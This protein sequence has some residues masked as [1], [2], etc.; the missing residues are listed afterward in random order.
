MSSKRAKGHSGGLLIYCNNK[1][2]GGIKLVKRNDKGIMW[3]KLTNDPPPPGEI[4]AL[5]KY[6]IIRNFDFFGCLSDEVRHFTYLGDVC[7][8]GDFNSRTGSLSDFV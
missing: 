5:F 3:I 1:F 7:L 2:A 6:C 4:K 8:R